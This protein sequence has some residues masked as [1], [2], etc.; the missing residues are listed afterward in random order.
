MG[1]VLREEEKRQIEESLKKCDGGIDYNFISYN[2]TTTLDKYLQY[3]KTNV[4]IG[5]RSVRGHAY[6]NQIKSLIHVHGTVEKDMIMGVDN[7]SQLAKPE[8]F[9]SV[10]PEYLADI[11]KIENNKMC[12]ENTDSKAHTLLNNS[13]FIY[14]YGMSLGKT[15]ATWWRRICEIMN[16]NKNAQTIIYKYDAPEREVLRRVRVTFDNEVKKNLTYYCDFDQDVKAEIEQRIHVQENNLFKA[17]SP[18]L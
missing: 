9:D 15:D 17:L 3:A 13:D 2:Y 10:A 1:F 18:S 12:G 7:L 6:K 14:I 16:K 11:I 8:I 5:D 4:N